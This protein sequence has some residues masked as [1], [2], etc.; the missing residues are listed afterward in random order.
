MAAAAAAPRDL[1]PGITAERYTILE[2]ATAMLDAAGFVSL[3]VTTPAS[4]F[5][6]ALDEFITSYGAIID[7]DVAIATTLDMDA[8]TGQEHIYAREILGEIASGARSAYAAKL[9]DR[10]KALQP[11]VFKAPPRALYFGV[12]PGGGGPGEMGIGVVAD[13]GGMFVV[14][15]LCRARHAHSSRARA[16]C[17][18]FMSMRRG[19]ARQACRR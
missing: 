2:R 6:A 13:T 9:L 8:A 12:D 7:N 3:G 19:R 10:A 1:P 18:C 16:H 14:S 4:R 5:H 11:Y 17:F 15:A